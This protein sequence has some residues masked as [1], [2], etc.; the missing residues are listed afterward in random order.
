MIIKNMQDSTYFKPTTDLLILYIIMK[1]GCYILITQYKLLHFVQLI[2]NL[3][4]Q[5]DLSKGVAHGCPEC[6]DCLKVNLNPPFES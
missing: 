3:P 4:P 1:T 6:S 2:Q 5:S